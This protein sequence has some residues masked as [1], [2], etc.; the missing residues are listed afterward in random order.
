MMDPK[1]HN[2]TQSIEIPTQYQDPITNKIMKEPIMILSS[3]QVYDN[4]T[5][6]KWIQS[7][8]YYDPMTGIP[9]S[10][11]GLP[12]LLQPRI[13][14]QKDINQFINKHPQIKSQ[15]TD[16]YDDYESLFKLRETQIKQKY[17]Q[18]EQEQTLLASVPKQIFGKITL[19]PNDTIDSIEIDSGFEL[20]N[21][22]ENEIKQFDNEENVGVKYDESIILMPHIP[23]ICIMGPSRNGKSTLVNDLL[24]VPNACAVSPD[25]GTALTKGAWIAKYS[26][27]STNV[28]IEGNMYQIEETKNIDNDMDEKMESKNDCKEFY[29]L[30]MEGL[31]NQ[32]TKYTKRLF[33]ACYAISNVMVWNDKEVAS[34]RFINLMHDL[35]D[36]MS[37]IA[38]SDKKPAFLYLKRDAGDFKYKPYKSFDEYVNNHKSFED[39]RKMDIF[40]SLSGH[41]LKRPI[42]NEN[43]QDEL[44]NFSSLEKNRVLIPPLIDKLLIVSKNSKRFSLNAYDLKQQIKYINASTGLSLT[45][46]LIAEDN[47]LSK[48]LIAAKDD[49][50]RQRDMI[51]IACEF[52]WNHKELDKKF[53]EAVE[54]LTSVQETAKLNDINIVKMNKLK[55][56]K[57][58]IY[59]RIK[60]KIDNQA[61]ANTL[62]MVYAVGTVAY[63]IGAFGGFGPVG[64]VVFGGL[65]Y[66]EGY[67]RG[68]VL[69]FVGQKVR[70]W[71]DGNY[72]R[73]SLG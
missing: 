67:A 35:E 43:D 30:D 39:F 53:N 54:K 66:L 1:K 68:K 55:V 7:K 47:V 46:K 6:T 36:E 73:Y 27:K 20:I 5:I 12:L 15:I 57:D 42:Q 37:T 59:E 3:M 40:S 17:Q 14:I 18:F 19:H 69:E 21:P 41:E 16:K 62:G 13:D 25:A 45:G 38:T 51:L 34:D 63:A 56:T 32:A 10:V 50:F 64:I 61:W 26:A 28:D 22:S 44:L 4:T 60:N 72:I 8:R 9:L 52:N 2:N 23:V 70:K 31:S 48:F 29:L 33:Y 71:I 58:E 49:H 24:G 65:G 11:G